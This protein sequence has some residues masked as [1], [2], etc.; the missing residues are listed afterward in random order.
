MVTN[1]QPSKKPTNKPKIVK[2]T[3]PWWKHILYRRLPS[4]AVMQ[5]GDIY[6]DEDE[7][8]YGYKTIRHTN[9]EPAGWKVLGAEVYRPRWVREWRRWNVQK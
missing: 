8:G 9:E 6:A 4:Q 5:P 7:D 1:F 2:T 3:M